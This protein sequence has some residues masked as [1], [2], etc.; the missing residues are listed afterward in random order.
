PARRSRSSASPSAPPV[1]RGGRAGASRAIPLGAW[2]NFTG[3]MG[4]TTRSTR[5]YLDGAC[6]PTH[7][8]MA[9]GR[10]RARAS[11]AHESAAERSV[12]AP[13]PSGP[14]AGE[15]KKGATYVIHL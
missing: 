8:D 11:R 14:P 10:T 3:D 9:A 1:I 15:R 2:N 13:S 7:A 6:S 4:G 5:L 12:P